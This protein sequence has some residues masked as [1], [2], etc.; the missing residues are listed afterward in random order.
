M[1]EKLNVSIAT[2]FLQ[3]TLQALIISNNIYYSCAQGITNIIVSNK[4]TS[5]IIETVLGRGLG[6]P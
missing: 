6:N 4:L 2:I 3:K 1:Y 5:W